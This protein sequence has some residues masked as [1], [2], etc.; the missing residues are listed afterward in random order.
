[1]LF[2][3]IFVSI[4]SLFATQSAVVMRDTINTVI[5]TV[6]AHSANP[7]QFATHHKPV[8]SSITQKMVLALERSHIAGRGVNP[9]VTMV[10]LN[11]IILLLLALLRGLFMFFQRQTLIVMSRRI[12]YDQKTDIYKHYQELHAGFYKSHFTG[13]LMNRIAEDVSRVRMYVGP[14]IMYATGTIAL[15][16]FCIWYMFQASP[17]LTLFVIIPLPVLAI[18]MY[19]INRVIFRKSGKIQAQLSDLTTTAQESYSGIRVIKSFVQENNILQF[20]NNTSDEYKKSTI[21]LAITDALYFPT[22]NL[23]IGFSILSIILVGGYLAIKGQI[24]IGNIAEFIMY[25]NLLTYSVSA[26]G[27]VASYVQRAGASQK[28]ID[29]FLQTQPDIQSPL[30]P[31]Q[32]IITGAVTLQHLSFTYAHTGITALKDINLQIKAGDKIAVL[33]R[34]GSGKSTLAHL[35]LRMYDPQTGTVLYDNINIKQFDLRSLRNQIAYAPQDAYLFSDTVYNN[36]KFGR[37]NATEQEVKEA[38]RL[39]DMEKDI[40]MLA[41]GYQTMIGERGVMLSGGQKQRLI[42]ARAL[43]KN[44]K[45]LILDD[46]L[47]AVDT[48]TEKNILNNLEGYL[49]DKTAIIT[50]HRIFTNLVFDKI[51]VLDN[52]SIAEQGT[53]E[54]LMELNG[55]Y[56]KLYNYQVQLDEQH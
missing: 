56:A 6:E 55:R 48:Q 7:A 19:Y 2:G 16:I 21:N 20:F 31:E 41:K 29:E 5:D 53:H 32:H 44:S 40:A 11:G 38:V 25:I 51:I 1:M 54:E 46:C 47:S 8:E 33:G 24:Q 12:E 18:S 17:L 3:L 15:V 43:L 22:V 42:L 35:L 50:T 27:M 34:T 28:R 13:D 30:K 39:A 36:I 23:L 45:L 52:G 9:I 4:S 14:S 26:L 49:K 10:F 37:D